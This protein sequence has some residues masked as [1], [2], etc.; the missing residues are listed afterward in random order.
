[1]G[2]D[3]SLCIE[4]RTAGAWTLVDP[5]ADGEGAGSAFDERNYECFSLLTGL[6]FSARR[7]R[8]LVAVASLRGLPPDISKEARA[9]LLKFSDDAA[10]GRS[11]L[12]VADLIAFDWDRIV[13]WTYFIFA[14]PWHESRRGSPCCC[15]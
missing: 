7:I 6:D 14:A 2:T 3:I 11:W 8:P 13:E 4:R 10:F 12:D 5:T 1:M 9:E 15:R